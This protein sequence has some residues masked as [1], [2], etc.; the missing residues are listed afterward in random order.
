MLQLELDV[1]VAV[2][3][4]WLYLPMG[5]GVGPWESGHCG[6]TTHLGNSSARFLK[7]FTAVVGS[8]FSKWED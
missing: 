2:L 7:V 5:E 1:K 6:P 3:L 4:V 8:P